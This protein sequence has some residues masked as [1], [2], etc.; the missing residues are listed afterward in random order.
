MIHDT[1]KTINEENKIVNSKFKVSINKRRNI[2]SNVQYDDR[3]SLRHPLTGATVDWW[4]AANNIQD[5]PANPERSL[6][7]L[8]DYQVGVVYSDEFGRQTPVQADDSGVIRIKK[9]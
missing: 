2:R 5:I 8:R 3:T 1:L 7:S 6:K 4:D 9:H